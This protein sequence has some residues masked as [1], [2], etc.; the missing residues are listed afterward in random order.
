MRKLK[1]GKENSKESKVLFLDFG[2]CSEIILR[3]VTV[4]VLF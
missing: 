1:T 4:I 3:P 2:L